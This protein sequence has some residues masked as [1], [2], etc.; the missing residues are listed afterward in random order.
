VTAPKFIYGFRTSSGYCYGFDEDSAR[1]A[2]VSDFRHWCAERGQIADIP[3]TFGPIYFHDAP[4]VTT[5]Y[6]NC[7]TNG[8][9][10][11]FPTREDAIA[12]ASGVHWPQLRLTFHDDVL[13]AAEVVKDGE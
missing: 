10:G 11:F 6:A 12:G 7:Y 5:K 4:V 2:C 3:D 9:G 8:Y 1:C 13:V